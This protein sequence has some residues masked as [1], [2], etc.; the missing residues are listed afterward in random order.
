VVVPHA[1]VV[2]LIGWAQNW[3]GTALEQVCATT[4]LAFDVSVFEIM[5][6][7]GQGGCVHL[8]DDVLALAANAD[9]IDQPVLISG[10]PSA[11]AAVIEQGALPAHP[12]TIVLAG[13]ALPGHLVQAISA[14]RPG[15]RVANIYGPTEVT[16]YATAWAVTDG[17]GAS[18]PIGQ[19]IWNTQA[20]VLDSGLRPVPAGVVGDLY[21]AGSGLARGYLGRPALSAE[22]FVANPFGPAGS[23]MYRTGD[24]VR[25]RA[26]GSLDFLG[27]SDHQVKIRGYRIELG[28][29][30]A[31][32]MADPS[33][34]QA[35]VV[36]REDKPGEKRL[37][38]YVV[39]RD[40]GCDPAALRRAVADAGLPDYMVPAAVVPLEAL[41]L[42]A[43]GKLDRKALP[44]PEFTSASLRAPRTPQ[45]EILA[46]LFA[47]LLGLERVGIDD[48][49]FD[50][51]GHS[52]LATRLIN[53]IRS[54]LGT[55]LP[56]RA[57]FE[58]PTVAGLVPRLGVS[59]QQSMFDVLLPLRPRDSGPKLFC[60]HPATGMSWRYVGLARQL[61]PEVALYGLQARGLTG[62]ESAAASVDEMAAD[63]LEQI[64]IVQPHGPYHLLG[65]SF[66]AVV[67]H[68]I[69]TQ[70]Q[71]AGD[72]VALLASL[73]GVPG[74][75]LPD[76]PPLSE[77]QRLQYWLD[78]VVYDQPYPSDRPLTREGVT[79]YIEE[80]ENPLAP[81]IGANLSTFVDTLFRSGDLLRAYRP[82]RLFD[83]DLMHFVAARSRSQNRLAPEI[84]RRYVTGT[85][86]C[87]DIDCEHQAMTELAP[88]EQIG[89][90]IAGRFQG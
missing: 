23:R 84:W 48:S 2:D 11:L 26:D 16:V 40:G 28:E 45:E 25:W 4:S 39:A 36:A 56:M 15:C 82:R 22:R 3:L 62:D 81:Y 29:I 61:P 60:I 49:F 7:L 54:T 6:P 64:R 77:S 44:A 42:T 1:G 79:A 5:A 63:Y 57:I 76:M 88:L 19:P 70:I 30:E 53:R 75:E 51:G 73:D 74:D 31:A 90:S 27:R 59:S 18:V 66:G 14:V 34:A 43:T 35:V 47:E 33:V 85:V 72:S 83:G 13:E 86:I 58:A 17:D 20:Y 78:V 89:R 38:G 9:R 10:V 24:L 80:I 87:H 8:F 46:A 69:A 52:L 55:E 65:W 41:P 71:E 67:A 68:A 12:T 37:V 21:L 50:L 32:L